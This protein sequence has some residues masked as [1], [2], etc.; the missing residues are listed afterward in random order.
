[1]TAVRA[2][3][4][5]EIR[6]FLRDRLRLGALGLF[7]VVFGV[8]FAGRYGMVLLV[9]TAL[10]TMVAATYAFSQVSFRREMSEKTM[11]ALLASPTSL[12]MVLLG[13]SFAVF[14]A[15]YAIE[16][17]GLAICV[18]SSWICVGRLPTLTS[19]YVST[20]VVPIWGFVVIELFGVAYSLVRGGVGAWL[21]TVPIYLAVL[22]GAVRPS[23]SEAIGRALSSSWLLPLTGLVLAGLLASVLAGLSKDRM[24]RVSS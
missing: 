9:P 16:M 22:L 10:L 20:V 23:T 19:V 5:K 3:F 1:M 6:S 15:S 14:V 2:I 21:L 13:K 24:T 12:G 7:V 11:P 17:V 8:Y 4:W 18:I